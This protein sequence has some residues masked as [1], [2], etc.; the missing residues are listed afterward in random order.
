MQAMLGS[1]SG[2]TLKWT[3]VPLGPVGSLASHAEYQA[4]LEASTKDKDSN[5]SLMIRIDIQ[6]SSEAPPKKRGF[7]SG[8]RPPRHGVH[9]WR[10][11]TAS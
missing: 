8:H 6:G 1:V 9:R 3:M 7:A 10:R 4:F 5:P 11:S 2:L